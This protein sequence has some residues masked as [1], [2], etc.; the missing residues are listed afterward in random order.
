[1]RK[2]YQ[3][4]KRDRQRKRKGLIEKRSSENIERKRD[5]EKEREKE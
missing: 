5:R 3:K 2:N 4:I 1:M